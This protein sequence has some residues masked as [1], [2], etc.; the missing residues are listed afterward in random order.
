ME[1]DGM[2]GRWRKGEEKG[3]RD[4]MGGGGVKSQAS[5][6]QGGPKLEALT[7][8]THTSSEL[9]DSRSVRGRME[10]SDSKLGSFFFLPSF[11][12]RAAV[13]EKG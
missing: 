12:T 8:H 10:K 5:R 2:R 13:I 3:G 7:S 4:G 11:L 1:E 6:R 9:S